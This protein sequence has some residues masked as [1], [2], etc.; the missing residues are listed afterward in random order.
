MTTLL[1]NSNSKSLRYEEIV[2]EHT[3]NW[4]PKY[5]NGC[6]LCRA[7]RSSCSGSREVSNNHYDDS[8]AIYQALLPIAEKRSIKVSRDFSMSE[9]Y[10]VRK[11]ISPADIPIGLSS[12]RSSTFGSRLSPFK[13]SIPT[14]AHELVL[15]CRPVQS[16]EF[17]NCAK[18]R[19]FFQGQARSHLRPRLEPFALAS[20]LTSPSP[21]PQ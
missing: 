3:D 15:D 5:H 10:M 14:I 21:S 19:P 2:R 12:M 6:G 8:S 17:E 11:A 13:L 20:C 7:Q 16:Q 18:K 4:E 1:Q 9:T